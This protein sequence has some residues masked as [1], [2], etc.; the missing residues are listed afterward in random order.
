MTLPERHRIVILF[1]RNQDIVSLKLYFSDN[2]FPFCSWLRLSFLIQI[3]YSLLF[4]LNFVGEY[5]TAKILNRKK[6]K[7]TKSKKRIFW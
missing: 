2:L 3:F 1:L 7:I 6:I 5:C 4:F